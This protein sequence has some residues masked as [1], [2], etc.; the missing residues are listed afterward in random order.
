MPSIPPL[1]AFSKCAAAVL[2]IAIAMAPPAPAVTLEQFLAGL[3]TSHPAMKTDDAAVRTDGAAPDNR[4]GGAG[5]TLKITPKAQHTETSLVQPGLPEKSTT[6]GTEMS[7]DKNF[8][9]TGTKLR[10]MANTEYVDQ[11]YGMQFTQPQNGP[12]GGANLS[13]LEQQQQQQGPRPQQ[14]PQQPQQ[15]QRPNLL[16]NSGGQYRTGVGIQIRQ[17]LIGPATE[18]GA[19][20]QQKSGQTEPTAK[21]SESGKKETQEK[22]LL[23][24]G[25]LYVDWALA[26]EK[27]KIASARLKAEEAAMVE[28]S[29][30][31][32]QAGGLDMIRAKEAVAIAKKSLA[33]EEAE[34]KA[35]TARLA[36]HYQGKSLGSAPELD[37]Y[38]QARGL[39]PDA[40][41]ALVGDRSRALQNLPQGKERPGR[42]DQG[43]T[44]GSK[45]R[46]DLNLG[47]GMVG[48]DKEHGKSMNM[49]KSQWNASLA[50]TIPFGGG[51]DEAESS[52][53][54]ETLKRNDDVHA[55]KLAL[56]AEASALATRMKET[57]KALELG[58]LQVA[59][60][61]E[62]AAA[63]TAAYAQ[64]KGDFA[65]AAQARESQWQ[66]RI[67]QAKDAAARWKIKLRLDEAL[68]AL[69]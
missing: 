63:E 59:A 56:M 47:A 16:L 37:L 20:G 49:N 38:S 1:S 26:A 6:Y 57:Y 35:I 23:Q 21:E 53:R 51:T 7:L 33:M 28:V 11:T 3:K 17:A 50:L 66:A 64:G 39:A 55:A 67:S 52:G 65:S 10:L 46:L 22:F 13:T 58:A 62:R 24:M 54:K 9:S 45:T 34:Q 31:G 42:N 2:F 48:E 61:A 4:G 36:V 27:V 41:A 32:G 12:Q 14:P 69:L 68:D 43:S 30:K 25:E 60:S 19:M 44:G 29:K 8:P 5:W 40:A 18:A 15:Q